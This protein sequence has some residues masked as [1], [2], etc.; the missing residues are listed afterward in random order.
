[1]QKGTEESS[2]GKAGETGTEAEG[3]GRSDASG[4]N[5]VG[6]HRD[7]RTV[8]FPGQHWVPSPDEAQEVPSVLSL[9]S[10]SMEDPA[11]KSPTARTTDPEHRSRSF[12]E[13]DQN[14]AMA[15]A[16]KE[17]TPPLQEEE[18][19][20]PFGDTAQ[21]LKGTPTARGAQKKAKKRVSF[22]ERLFVEEDTEQ[23]TELEEEDESHPQQLARE[24]AVAGDVPGEE[25]PECPHTAGTGEGPVT[26]AASESQS[27]SEDPT[28]EASPARGTQP[29]RVE[30][31]DGFVTQYQSKASDHEGLLSDPLSDLPSAS[32]LKSPIMADLSLSL[33]SI[34]EVASDDERVDEAGHGG[35]AARL[36][37][38]EVGVSPTNMSPSHLEK[39]H[40]SVL[41]ENRHDSRPRA[42]T[43]PPSEQTAALG[44][45]K[46]P[47]SQSS[48]VNTQ[49]PGPGTV[50]EE[51]VKQSGRPDPPP[52]ISQD[53][54]VPSPSSSETFPAAR[55]LPSSPYSDS[56]HGSVAEPPNKAT[57]EGPAGK[58]ETVGK[59][60]PL[61]QAWVT[62]S[63]IHPVSAPPSAG[64]GAA[65]HR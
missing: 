36:V 3:Q 10:G 51:E 65:K 24:G 63:E 26:T 2:E 42:P 58:V 7:L 5:P 32:D 44:T 46:P 55:S 29:L 21:R 31:S 39:A 33:P 59:K 18:A 30:E 53:P 37:D 25:S 4:N 12:V 34:P 45:P 40:G 27:F 60:K 11:E 22:S 56:H 9:S 16:V 13:N 49:L 23:P 54:P 41:T 15:S 17:A 8:P 50:E 20:S 14:G 19:A 52:R 28:S 47:L 48:S 38:L 43:A 35:G 62:P 61:L 57:A 1:M 6:Q 64:A